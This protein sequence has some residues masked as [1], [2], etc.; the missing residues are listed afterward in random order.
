MLWSALCWP[1]CSYPLATKLFYKKPAFSAPGDNKYNVTCH[2]YCV[3]AWSYFLHWEGEA[4]LQRVSQKWV[5][6]AKLPPIAPK[7]P[8]TPFLMICSD[9][10]SAQSFLVSCDCRCLSIWAEV[11]QIKAHYGSSGAKGLCQALQQLSLTFCVP[12]EISSDR[13]SEFTN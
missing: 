3:L 2:V 1:H 4:N 9:Y 7:I 10:F 11:V 13:G 5:I 6:T 8:N 12:E